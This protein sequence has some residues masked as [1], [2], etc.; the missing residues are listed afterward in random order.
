MKIVNEKSSQFFL[1]EVYCLKVS[2]MCFCICNGTARHLKLFYTVDSNIFIVSTTNTSSRAHSV[3][4]GSWFAVTLSLRTHSLKL[5]L[6]FWLIKQI[7][8]IS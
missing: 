6:V 8:E 7:Y 3:L 2:A 5:K 1:I 4:K